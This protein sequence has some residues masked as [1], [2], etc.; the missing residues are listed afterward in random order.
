VKPTTGE[1]AAELPAA[2]L[3]AL[4]QVFVESVRDYAIFMLDATGHV[5]SWNL[6]AEKIKQYSRDEVLGQHFSRFYPPADVRDG[7]CERLLEA[8]RRDGSSEDFGWRVRKDGSRFFA[9]VVITPVVGP[10]GGLRGY[11]KVV[12][13]LSERRGVEESLRLSE[14]RFRLLV[15]A[16]SDY[17]IFMLDPQGNVAS[18]NPGAERTKGYRREEI[19]GHHFSRF[20]PPED[21]AAGKCELELRGALEQGRFEDEGWRVRKDGTRFWANVVITPIRSPDGTPLGFAKVTRDLTTRRQAETAR[22]HLAEAQAAQR[23]AEE[24]A[25]ERSQVAQE[26]EAMNSKLKAALASRDDFLAVASHELRTPLHIL[27]MQVTSS[28]FLIESGRATDERLK[29]RLEKAQAELQRLDDLLT[30]LLDVSR[31]AAGRLHVEQVE[32]D[33]VATT[34]EIVERARDE[35]ARSGC[36]ISLIAPGEL[37]GQWDPLRIEQ[38]ITNLLSNAMKYGERS[39]VTIELARIGERVQIVVSDRGLGIDPADRERIFERFERAVSPRNVSGFGLGLWIVRQILDSMGGTIRVEGE[40]G[41]GSRFI[42][43]LPAS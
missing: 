41:K 31:I 1:A 38:V 2:E 39:P 43:D 36:P 37:R 24:R 19:L 10:D 26:L 21:V 35:S 17:A 11:T 42:V 29:G 25:R 9:H 32:V 5:A 4:T 14:E 18:W 12:R 28:Q 22:L 13:D 15:D 23:A 16:V 33:L 27:T 7:K 34:R 40:K 8:A 20:Y 30:K 3:P 6:G